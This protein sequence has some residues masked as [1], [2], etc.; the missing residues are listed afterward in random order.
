[1]TVASGDTEKTI[2]AGIKPYYKPEELIGRSVVVVDNLEPAEIRGIVS[3]G[4]LLA[5]KDDKS[6]AILTPDKEIKAGSPVS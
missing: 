2:V 3:N 4:M 5:A 1:M 6:F